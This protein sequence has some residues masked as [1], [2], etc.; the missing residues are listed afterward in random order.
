MDSNVHVTLDM[1]VLKKV[2]SKAEKMQEFQGFLL[3]CLNLK[4]KRVTSHWMLA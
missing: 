3:N 1:Q 2:Y 4:V